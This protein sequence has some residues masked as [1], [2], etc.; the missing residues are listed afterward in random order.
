MWNFLDAV[1]MSSKYNLEAADH[2]HSRTFVY[3]PEEGPATSLTLP[4]F[5]TLLVVPKS[6]CLI[7]SG[8]QLRGTRCVGKPDSAL[9]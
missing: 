7:V 8:P 3:G 9:Q 2:P 4:C 6:M 1:A 5:S